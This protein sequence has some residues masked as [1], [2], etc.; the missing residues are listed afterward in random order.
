MQI[1]AAIDSLG[2]TYMALLT[3]HVDDNNIE[4]SDAIYQEFVVDGK[5]P[6]DGN[7]EWLYIPNNFFEDWLTTFIPAILT[8][9]TMSPLLQLDPNRRQD[10]IETYC[11]QMIDGMDY[12]TMEQLVFD[13]LSDG[14]TNLTDYE[15]CDEVHNYHGADDTEFREFAEGTLT[16]DEISAYLDDANVVANARI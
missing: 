16:D 5:D 3:K 8:N 2:D 11:N 12:K 1:Q 10:L 13:L 7:Y 15:L 9:K 4:Y 14:M 6:E